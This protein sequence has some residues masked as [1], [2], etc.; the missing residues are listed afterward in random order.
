[1]SAAH[2]TLYAFSALELEDHLARSDKGV[3]RPPSNLNL[4]TA[5]LQLELEFLSLKVNFYC[6]R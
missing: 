5:S 2:V 6:A 4:I 1:V 3:K